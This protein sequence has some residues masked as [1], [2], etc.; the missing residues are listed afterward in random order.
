[1]VSGHCVNCQ[2]VRI[3]PIVYVVYSCFLALFC[4]QDENVCTAAWTSGHRLS[5]DDG[6]ALFVLKR[7]TAGNL[8]SSLLRMIMN[9][10][11][12]GCLQVQLQDGTV[13][14]SIEDCATKACVICELRPGAEA[15][16][17]I[18]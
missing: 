10:D 2:V 13:R 3:A 14:W 5:S 7:D 6:S 18:D 15:E 9:T 17:E 8:P 1:M 11:K 4:F 16:N 12:G